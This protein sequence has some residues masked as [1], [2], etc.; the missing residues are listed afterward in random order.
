MYS[1]LLVDKKSRY[2]LIYP[3]QNLTSDLLSQLQQFL[4]DVNGCCKAIR[5]DFD[6]KLIGGKVKAFLLDKGI[7]IDAAPPC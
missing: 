2:K 3:L 4:I 6:H 5:T 7:D 1:L